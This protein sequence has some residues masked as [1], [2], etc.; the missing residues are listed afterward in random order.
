MYTYAKWFHITESRLRIL[1]RC[2]TEKNN[3]ETFQQ[4]TDEE[5][6]IAITGYIFTASY[7]DLWLR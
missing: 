4:F 7:Y 5:H 2:I 3:E 6:D 1:V